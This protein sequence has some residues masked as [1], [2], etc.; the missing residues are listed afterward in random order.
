MTQFWTLVVTGLVSGAIYSLIATCLTLSYQTTGIFNLGYGAIAFTSA[1]VYYI[2]HIGVGW[3]IVPAA[4]VT[5]LVIGPGVGWVLDRLI[6]RSLTNATDATKIMTTVGVLVF[7]PALWYLLEQIA[8]DLGATLPDTTQVASAPGIG[9]TKISTWRLAGVPLNSNQLAVFA[10][11]ALVA[12]GMWILMRHTRLGLTMRAMV[13]KPVLAE[14][15]GVN[16]GRTSMLAWMIGCSLAALTG[17]VAAP[18]FNAL[19]PSTYNEIM[20]VSIAAAV[21]GAFKSIPI[22]FVSGLLLGVL[23]SLLARYATFASSIQGFNSAVPFIVLLVG[24]TIWGRSRS[25]VAGTATETEVIVDYTSDLSTF[26]RVLPWAVAGVAL[27]LYIGLIANEFWLAQTTEGLGLAIVFLSF[28]VITGL[29]GMVSLAQA[30]FVGTAGM[31]IGLLIDHYHV[32]FLLAVLV[33]VVV[34]GLLG[35]LIALPALRISG[36]ALALATLALGFLADNVLFQWNW[37]ANGFNGWTITPPSVGPFHLSNTKTLAIVLLVVTGLVVILTRN[38]QRSAAGRA[39]VAMNASDAGAR[40]SGISPTRVKLFV[41]TTGAAIAGL[42][43]AALVVY[44]GSITNSSYSTA[45]SLLWLAGVVLWGIRRPGSAVIAGISVALFPALIS[46]GFHFSFL[47]WNGTRNPFI[48]ELLF[49]LGAIQMA[50]DPNGLLSFNAALF[51]AGREKRAARAARRSATPAMPAEA[52]VPAATV[53]AGLPSPEGILAVDKV[54]AGYG[55]IRVLEDL[56]LTLQPATITAVLGPNGAGKSTLCGVLSGVNS[57][58]SGR[59]WFAGEDVTRLASHSRYGRGL[60]LAPESRGVFPGMSVDD[61]L[62][63]LLPDASEREEA[64]RR[65]PHL[66]QRR[67]LPAGSLSGGEQQILTMAPLLIHPPKVLVADEPTLGL[68]PLVAAQILKLFKELKEK[69]VTLLLVEEKA[70]AVLEI[71][72]NVAILELGRIVWSG[73]AT[74]LKDDALSRAYLG[75]GDEAEILFAP[76]ESLLEPTDT[77]AES[78]DP[79]ISPFRPAGG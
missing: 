31:T 28:V 19:S 5:M 77:V 18:I 12:L 23:E 61:N 49:G 20:F 53:D 34:T 32:P 15:R 27:C 13:D 2:I 45:T 62:S 72:D 64:Y 78:P 38:L 22:A 69:G 43:G 14:E 41:V 76:G 24:V 36:L 25:R 57:V 8:N 29:G 4:I 7:L 71:A 50:K 55:D 44:S 30:A 39:A 33:G 48:P 3:P 47:T 66:N 74:A 67:S 35:L 16:R 40:M 21:V 60:V 75:A 46:G 42:G 11:A 58:T 70:K 63:L 9:P 51:R 52:V 73:A 37:F 26:R 6:F 68:A 54:S 1:F 56:S 10:T 59:L 17:L 79:A 65:F